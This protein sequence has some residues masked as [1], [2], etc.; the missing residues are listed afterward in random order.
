MDVSTIFFSFLFLGSPAAQEQMSGDITYTTYCVGCHGVDGK[1]NG[2]SA[3]FVDDKSHLAKSD[4]ELISSIKN[5]K[6]MMPAYGWMLS[7]ETILTVVQYIRETY[8]N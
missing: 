3:N 5:G 8:G 6:G 4:E 1:G 7:D 2:S